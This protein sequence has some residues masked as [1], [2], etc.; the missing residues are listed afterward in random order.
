MAADSRLRR[1][2]FC[3]LASLS[4]LTPFPLP[5]SS[6]LSLRSSS[7]ASEKWLP[8]PSYEYGRFSC[9]SVRVA[10]WLGVTVR[11]NG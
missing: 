3:R 2:R 8:S 10:A 9:W 11:G 5:S 7:G 4:S 1:I 6:R